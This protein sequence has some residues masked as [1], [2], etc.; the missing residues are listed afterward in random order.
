M[1]NK[2]CK[3]CTKSL[4]ICEDEGLECTL[5]KENVHLK[6]LKRGSVP[7]GFNGD[8]FYDFTCEQCTPD[9]N[10]NFVRIKMSW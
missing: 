9:G 4:E 7:G 10:E 5:C 3:Y 6:C 2:T 1:E 8:V